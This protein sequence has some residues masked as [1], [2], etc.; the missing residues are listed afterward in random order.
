MSSNRRKRMRRAADPC[1]GFYFPPSSPTPPSASQMNIPP[2][3]VLENS[4]D[5]TDSSCPEVDELE[6]SSTDYLTVDE[7]LKH[8]HPP[9][10]NTY[11]KKNKRTMVHDEKTDTSQVRLEENYGT[12]PPRKRKLLQRKPL[13]SRLLTAALIAD[14]DPDD[15]L[16]DETPQRTSLVFNRPPSPMKILPPKRPRKL[17]D[18]KSTRLPRHNSFPCA[19]GSAFLDRS[20]APCQQLNTPTEWRSKLRLPSNNANRKV[21]KV[22]PAA[23][24]SGP[25]VYAP[26]NLISHA[27]AERSYSRLRSG[28]REPLLDPLPVSQ[29]GRIPLDLRSISKPSSVKVATHYQSESPTVSSQQPSNGLL[30]RGN[31]LPSD[32]VLASNED[33]DNTSSVSNI[34]SANSDTSADPFRATN[35]NASMKPLG[36]LLGQLYEIS[37]AVS[38]SQ[39]NTK[40]KQRRPKAR[41]STRSDALAPKSLMR[42]LFSSTPPPSITNA[43]LL[44]PTLAAFYSDVPQVA[45][46][47]SQFPIA[48]ATASNSS[49]AILYQVLLPSTPP[50]SNVQAQT[51]FFEFRSR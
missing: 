24:S 8:I 29:T 17:I 3:A 38:Q 15:F 49:N 13:K 25:F 16:L 20:L 46:A 21:R 45:Q 11:H 48:D 18:T 19:R 12:E 28:T 7:F 37:R 4:S 51:D 42:N 6:T 32:A 27:E 34:E 2:I 10:K 35:S 23:R 5:P 47:A 36:S 33:H 22:P 1:L 50:P 31:G 43:Q 30:A 40:S 14:V 39:V 26:L 44:S 9:P 41:R